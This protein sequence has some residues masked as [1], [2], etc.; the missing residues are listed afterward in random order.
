MYDA[1]SGT[2]KHSALT[3]AA[4]VEAAQDAAYSMF[5]AG[6]HTGITF[7][8]SD[9]GNSMA[10]AVLYG[11]TVATA[12]IGNDS[13]LSDARTPTA[14]NQAASTIT[15]GTF[16]TGTWIF[17]EASTVEIRNST[18]A[19]L[20]LTQASGSKYTDLECDSTGNLNITPVGGIVNVSS[21]SAYY[22]QVYCINTTADASAPYFGFKKAHG[23][24][25]IVS[26]ADS[27]GT[28][29]WSAYNGGYRS[30]AAIAA[31][32]EGTPDAVNYFTPVRLV[33]STASTTSVPAE[34]LRITS[35]GNTRPG[36]D[37]TYDLGEASYRWQ[38]IF[39]IYLGATA[40]R[41]TNGYFTNITTTNAVTVDSDETAKTDI[42]TSTLGLNLIE[43]LRPV[44]YKW[45]NYD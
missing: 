34:R 6:S 22:P 23:A 17:G 35:A 25:T 13:R 40:T 3:S 41:F 44:S 21:T 26:N 16:P 7:T 32:V 31:V 37:N 30:V 43:K 15:A 38:D 42:V 14:H 4:I 2:W 8:Y 10:G 9:I 24:A 27:L 11:T 29:V 39:G 33:I 19:Q 12:C 45:E 5:N 36:A 18:V 28:L 1:A 20:R